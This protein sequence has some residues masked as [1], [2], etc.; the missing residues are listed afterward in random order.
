MKVT[1]FDTET[2]GLLAYE[3]R[4]DCDHIVQLC[5]IQYEY[6][7]ETKEFTEIKRF[8]KLIK[9]PKKIPTNISKINHIYQ[10]DIINEKVFS[11]Y[12]PEILT[13]ND[14]DVWI[15]QNVYFDKNMVE[16]EFIKNE[17]DPNELFKQAIF[18]DTMVLKKVMKGRSAKEINLW[19]HYFPDR[20]LPNFHNAFEDVMA[21]VEIVKEAI[22]EG[23]ID[24]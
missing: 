6:N 11:F 21:L 9:S 4:P 3:N 14:T 5:M 16:L 19:E 20:N 10:R 8:N 12:I 18:C 13:Y 1:F 22:K 24:L 2:T 7:K 15:G 23:D 17:C